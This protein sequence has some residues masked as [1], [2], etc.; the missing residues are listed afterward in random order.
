MSGNEQQ[1]PWR[2]SHTKQIKISGRRFYKRRGAKEKFTSKSNANEANIR[3][4]KY[5]LRVEDEKR[6]KYSN[7][8]LAMH[9]TWYR[10]TLIYCYINDLL[11]LQSK[12]QTMFRTN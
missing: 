9:L 1:A 3:W 11:D 4:A 6:R 12:L 8:N 2:W 10:F 5:I 7:Y